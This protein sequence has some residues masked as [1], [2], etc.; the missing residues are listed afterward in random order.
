MTH[1][2]LFYSSMLFHVNLCHKA[3]D[4]YEQAFNEGAKV[5]QCTSACRDAC[6]RKV[7]M[8]AVVRVK[9]FACAAVRYSTM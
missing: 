9:R 6:L 8:L 1:K 7:E 5:N 2:V 3:W 4:C